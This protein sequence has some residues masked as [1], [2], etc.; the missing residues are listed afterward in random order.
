MCCNY[1]LKVTIRA[2]THIYDQSGGIRAKVFCNKRNISV[3][4]QCGPVG[5]SVNSTVMLQGLT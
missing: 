1:E 4:A 5:W 3:P 2:L